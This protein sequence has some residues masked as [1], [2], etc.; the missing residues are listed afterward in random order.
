MNYKEFDYTIALNDCS[1]VAVLG[2][3]NNI[4]PYERV[5]QILEVE[6]KGIGTKLLVVTYNTLLEKHKPRLFNLDGESFEDKLV[7]KTEK[8]IRYGVV[9]KGSTGADVY[10]GGGHSTKEKA[11][12]WAKYY[13]RNYDPNNQ[14]EK[15]Y[16]TEITW[17]E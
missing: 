2:N 1:K 14:I 15:F 16:I 9:Y 11:E 12:S 4:D 5:D 13:K 6:L 8:Q 10:V 7:L 17:E 3:N